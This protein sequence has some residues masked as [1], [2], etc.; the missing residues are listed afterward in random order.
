MPGSLPT[1]ITEY[2]EA[3][4]TFDGDRLIERPPP[5]RARARSERRPAYLSRFDPVLADVLRKV[6][7]ELADGKI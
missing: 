5:P 1:A 7:S 6:D 2:I 4:N 3:S